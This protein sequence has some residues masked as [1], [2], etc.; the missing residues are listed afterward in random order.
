MLN[1][2]D[3]RLVIIGLLQWQDYTA[4]TELEEALIVLWL[5]DQGAFSSRYYTNTVKAYGLAQE[6]TTPYTSEQNGLVEY[7]FRS[8]KEGEHLFLSRCAKPEL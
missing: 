5:E 1:T 6:F 8:P 2:R 7:F 4:K 3:L